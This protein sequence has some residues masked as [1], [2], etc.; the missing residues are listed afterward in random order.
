MS[1]PY[2]IRESIGFGRVHEHGYYQL[3]EM[4][5]DLTHDFKDADVEVI[6]TP[7]YDVA[8]ESGETL[9]Q[10]DVETVFKML[11]AG[12]PVKFVASRKDGDIQYIRPEHKKSVK[13]GGI[14][15]ARR[16]VKQYD[17]AVI[18]PIPDEFNWYTV[19]I[20]D[21]YDDVAVYRF[22]DYDEAEK[23]FKDTLGKSW[24][25]ATTWA[26]N[27]PIFKSIEGEPI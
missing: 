22:N 15:R 5:Y 3:D 23:R 18:I 13:V 27:T 14:T 21:M 7:L 8:M 11:S 12:L 26:N 16:G 20:V 10:L 24:F 25:S 9:S 6:T 17:T 1:C 4:V 2:I 19:A